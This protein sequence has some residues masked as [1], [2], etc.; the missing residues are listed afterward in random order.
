MSAIREQ[1]DWKVDETLAAILKSGLIDVIV[2]GS[3]NR[4]DYSIQNISCDTLMT[5]LQQ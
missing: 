5:L 1:A 4:L 3:W 2:V